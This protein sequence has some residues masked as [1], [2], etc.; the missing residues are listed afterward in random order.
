MQL[1]VQAWLVHQLT[2]SGFILGLVS[3]TAL[4]P[5]LIFG[6]NGGL[7]ADRLSRYRLFV[8][9][10]ILAMLQALI[11]YHCSLW[12]TSIDRGLGIHFDCQ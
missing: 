2:Q 12:H 9:T 6:L 5:I 10:Q 4:V 8:I 11:L 7:L 3:A 1:V